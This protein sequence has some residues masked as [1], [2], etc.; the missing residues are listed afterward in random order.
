LV[1]FEKRKTKNNIIKNLKKECLL[2]GKICALLKKK[3]KKKRKKEKNCRGRRES[4]EDQLVFKIFT[5]EDHVCIRD[6]PFLCCVPTF[7]FQL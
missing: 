3:E 1:A 4:R 6:F 5:L 2:F 7:V